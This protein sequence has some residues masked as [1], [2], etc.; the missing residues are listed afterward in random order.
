M[1]KLL[2]TVLMT[3]GLIAL[4]GCAEDEISSSI[5]ESAMTVDSENKNTAA[6][7]ASAGANQAIASDSVPRS[8]TQNGFDAW[9]NKHK[10][11]FGIQN[12]LATRNTI[13]DISSTVCP[14]GGSATYVVETNS[15]G[16]TGT[17]DVT[18]NNCQ[19]SWGGETTTIN[20]TASWTVEESGAFSYEYDLTTT[21]DG[22]TWTIQGTLQC[23]ASFNCSYTEDFSADG[24]DYR[25]ANVEISGGFGS[26]YNASFRIYHEELGYIDVAGENLVLCDN[27]NFQSGTISVTDST[28]SDALL[29]A[30]VSCSQMTVTFNGNAETVSQ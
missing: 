26:G 22:Q 8:A 27:G 14:D 25:L 19:D 3:L 4:V 7:S 20:G 30:F 13:I 2:S 15:S 10:N 23:D 12:R 28:N 6:R 24:V 21:A 1:K 9:V 11:L 17:F 29:I 16:T 18:Y 5:N